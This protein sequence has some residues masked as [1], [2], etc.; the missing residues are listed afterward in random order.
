MRLTTEMMTAQRGPQLTA[1]A[2]RR[3]EEG[4]AEETKGAPRW[5]GAR[6]ALTAAARR[7][8]WQRSAWR[9]SNV[10]RL[11]GSRMMGD[12]FLWIYPR[13]LGLPW[14]LTSSRR[15]QLRLDTHTHLLE[16]LCCRGVLPHE[17]TTIILWVVCRTLASSFFNCLGMVR[18]TNCLMGQFSVFQT[19]GQM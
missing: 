7:W 2:V 17:V 12:N 16:L 1:A 13:I 18:A 3:A 5:W 4:T 8:R 15:H 14:L 11:L 19:I 6:G 9:S 10:P